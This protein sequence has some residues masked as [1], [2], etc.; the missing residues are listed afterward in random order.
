MNTIK[1]VRA[2]LSQRAV[3]SDD[4]YKHP[5][6]FPSLLGLPLDLFW[7]TKNRF[8]HIDLRRQPRNERSVLLYLHI[9]W[10]L[11]V[12]SSDFQI[13]LLQ[14]LCDQIKRQHFNVDCVSRTSVSEEM[15]FNHHRLTFARLK[16]HPMEEK[17]NACQQGL[18]T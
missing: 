16:H 13:L 9:L 8:T 10:H 12:V 2:V 3:P 15:R 7:R 6:S 17:P 18:A 5:H 1:L 11:A 4:R 14:P